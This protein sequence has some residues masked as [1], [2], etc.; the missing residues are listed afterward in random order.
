MIRNFRFWI[1]VNVKVFLDAFPTKDRLVTRHVQG[2]TE[3][4]I[5]M[6]ERVQGRTG[7]F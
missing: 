4:Q 3:S 7:P 1:R 6:G 5:P 2:V